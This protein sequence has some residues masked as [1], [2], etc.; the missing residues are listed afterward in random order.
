MTAAEVEMGVTSR[1]SS[2]RKMELSA[3]LLEDS[4]RFRQILS[5]SSSFP[6]LDSVHELVRMWGLSFGSIDAQIT[7]GDPFLTAEPD[8]KSFPSSHNRELHCGEVV[9]V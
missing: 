2:P 8:E 5:P 7:S 3:A 6:R 9:G 1:C 4:G